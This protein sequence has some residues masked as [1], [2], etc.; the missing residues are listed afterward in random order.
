MHFFRSTDRQ[1]LRA[2]LVF[3]LQRPERPDTTR[4]TMAKHYKYDWTRWRPCDHHDRR[5]HELQYSQHR[6]WEMAEQSCHADY[7]HTGICTGVADFE[8]DCHHHSGILDAGH[9]HGPDRA[10]T[11]M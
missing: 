7:N 4:T 1:C 6:V 3:L 10:D 8:G 5:I 9:D 2:V 11:D